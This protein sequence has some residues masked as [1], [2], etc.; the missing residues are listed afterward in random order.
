MEYVQ[1]GGAEGVSAANNN[2]R[3]AHAHIKLKSAEVAEVKSALCIICV[4]TWLELSLARL[5]DLVATLRRLIIVSTTHCF[6]LF[7][8]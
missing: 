3:N 6:S 7:Q 4:H 2:S 8:I 5:F 1:T